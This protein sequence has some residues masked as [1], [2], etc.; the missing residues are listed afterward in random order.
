MQKAFTPTERNTEGVEFEKARKVVDAQIND[1]HDQLSDC[2]YNNWRQG[3]SKP[4]VVGARSWD[5][6]ATP[7][8]SKDLFDKLHG[9]IFLHHERKLFEFN[10]ALPVKEQDA[11]LKS[12]GDDEQV[13]ER[14]GTII[15]PRKTTVEANIAALKAEGFELDI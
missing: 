11:R 12:R 2:Y 6:Q 5:V 9:L 15:A 13:S 8:E 7:A 10:D 3:N 4:F 1:L 14:T